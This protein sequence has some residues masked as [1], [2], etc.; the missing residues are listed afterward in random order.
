[1]WLVSQGSRIEVIRP[2]SLR[3]EMKK[4]AEEILAH[5]PPNG[6]LHPLHD[7]SEQIG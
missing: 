1:M 6:C 4:K 3:Q 7:G 5:F 2:E